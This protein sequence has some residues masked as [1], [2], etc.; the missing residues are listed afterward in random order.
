MANLNVKGQMFFDSADYGWSEE[1]YFNTPDLSTALASLDKLL[2]TRGAL[3]G[4]GVNIDSIRVSDLD[5][6][7]STLSKTYAGVAFKHVLANAGPSTMPWDSYLLRLLSGTT[8]RRA[9][10]L[11]APPAKI[12][13]NPPDLPGLGDWKKGVDAYVAALT[14]Q[15]ACMKVQ[16][17]EATNPKN[18]ITAITV[19][20]VPVFTTSLPHNLSVGQKVGIHNVKG[21]TS[22]DPTDKINGQHT[23]VVVI[24]P[25]QFSP[26]YQG[27][28]AGAY[29]TG[30]YCRPNVRFL[31]PITDGLLIRETERHTGRP[32]GLARGRR[33]A[34]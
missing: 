14:K 11:H 17:R 25:T 31:A 8:Y 13:T 22:N 26:S 10:W 2:T 18:P 6:Q 32:T 9:Y 28:I 24:S 7:G 23:V 12:F 29:V 1:V 3:F 21:L 5:N 30:G 33:A 16:S 4:D 27:V 19:G 20:A 34:A 15:G